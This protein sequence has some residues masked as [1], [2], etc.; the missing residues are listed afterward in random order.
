M[1]YPPFV[2]CIKPTTIYKLLQMNLNFES[3]IEETH[4]RYMIDIVG[5]ELLTFLSSCLLN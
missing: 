4:V 2:T 5:T 3:Y 1:P